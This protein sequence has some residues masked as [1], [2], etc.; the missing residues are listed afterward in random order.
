[1][2][3][4]ISIIAFSLLALAPGDPLLAIRLENPRAVSAESIA[5]LR[6]YYHLDDPIYVRYFHWLRSVLAGDWG[7]SSVY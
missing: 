5:R 1:M 4:L 2:L 3:L 7:Y 6:E